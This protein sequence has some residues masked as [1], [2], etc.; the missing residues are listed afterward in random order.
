MLYRSTSVLFQILFEY[1]FICK[2]SRNDLLP[3]LNETKLKKFKKMSRFRAIDADSL[4]LVRI[5]PRQDLFR[6][7]L[8][9]NL[10]TLWFFVRQNFIARK[11]RV[12]P[13]LE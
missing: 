7:C 4:Y 2:I 13:T 10:T 6:H 5:V 8:Q 12:I 9:E 3:W 11:N 1:E